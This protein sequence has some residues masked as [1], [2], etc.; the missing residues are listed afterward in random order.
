MPKKNGKK[1]RYRSKVPRPMNTVTCRLSAVFDLK[2]GDA[3]AGQ[4][5]FVNATL[6]TRSL[7]EAY[8]PLSTGTPEYRPVNN[9]DKFYSLFDLYK[10]RKVHIK[11][12]PTYQM[13]LYDETGKQEVLPPLVI[14]HDVDNLIQFDVKGQLGDA[15]TKMRDPSRPWKLSF[16]IPQPSGATVDVWQNAQ[17]D[18][19]G[20]FRSGIISINSTA[21]MKPNA[22]VGTLYVT[23]DVSFKERQDTNIETVLDNTHSNE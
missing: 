19:N 6:Y 12:V 18:D 21:L 2:S 3:A 13:E 23:Y 17:Q 1:K 9:Y 5:A 14:S 15:Q 7:K 10:V 8:R 22:Q 16:T 20:F 4:L 11:Y